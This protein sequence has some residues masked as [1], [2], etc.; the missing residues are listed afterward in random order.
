MSWQATAWAL[1]QRAGSPAAKLVLLALANYADAAGMCWPSQERLATDTE[2]SVRTVQ[3][4][5]DA[6]VKGGL[7]RME[8]RNGKRGQFARCVYFLDVGIAEMSERQFDVRSGEPDAKH[9]AADHAPKCRA[10]TRQRRRPPY[11]TAVSHKPSIE[12]SI[13]PSASERAARASSE[14]RLQAFQGKREGDEVVQ[15]RI[16]QRLGRDGWSILGA[17]SNEQLAKLTALERKHSLHDAVLVAASLTK[18]PPASCFTGPPDAPTQCG[19][20]E[21]V[22][23]LATRGFGKVEN[24][25]GGEFQ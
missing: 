22:G 21:R 18:R 25:S 11:D 2:Q 12:P 17:M 6:L 19:Q 13:E 9:Q 10:A 3:R 16:A 24:S 1:R 20:T 23:S 15:N 14:E 8:K 5:V 7:I 4:H